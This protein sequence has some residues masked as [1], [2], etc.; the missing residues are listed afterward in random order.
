MRKV[1][2]G[3]AN[4]LDN[5]IARED[6]AVDWLRWGPEV[7]ALVS[8]MW[9]TV[10]TVLMGRKTYEEAL[11]LGSDGSP[12]PVAR[13][14]VLSRTWPAGRRGPVEIVNADAVDFVRTLK[15]EPGGDIC[16]MGGGVLG[17]AMLDAGLVD[18]LGVNIHPVLLGR[19]VPL[20]HP[21]SRQVE[22]ERLDCQALGNG[23]VYV[24]YRVK[25]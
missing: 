11:R 12:F 1:V 10:D 14:C 3:C 16:L 6:G 4:S 8:A 25:H 7:A 15:Q 17:A 9:K 19:G 21:L 13:T 22:L 5:F 23:C 2:F 20:F 24:L 18:E